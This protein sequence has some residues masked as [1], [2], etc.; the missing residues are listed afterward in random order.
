MANEQAQQLLQ[1]GIAAAKAGQ[2]DEA[3]RLLQEAIR[4]DATNETAWLWLSGVA[5]N[6]EE[7]IF[8][9]M[10]ILE[11]NPSNQNALKG[12][13]KLGV[14]PPSSTGIRRLKDQ[15]PPQGLEA[16]ARPPTA[17][18]KRIGAE[19]PPS[20]PAKPP[21]SDRIERRTAVPQPPVPILD[22]RRIA[23]L[24]EAAS[25][26]LENYQRLPEAALP[27]AWTRKTR[28]RIG[29][30][31][32]QALRL[33]IGAAFIGGIAVL[34]GAVFLILNL[35]GDGGTGVALRG[36]NTPTPTPTPTATPTF[37]LTNTPS[38]TPPVPRTATATPN[39]APGSIYSPTL[40]P[41]FPELRSGPLR[42]ALALLGAA[43]YAAALE[44]LEDERKGLELAKNETYY[45]IIYYMVTAY[46]AQNRPGEAARLL[47]ANRNP[48][49]TAFRAARALLS[50]A[51]GDLDTALSDALFVQRADPRW[52]EVAIVAARVQ[53]QRG[54]LAAARDVLRNAISANPRNVRLLL[55]RA[56]INLSGGALND[57]LSDAELALYIDPLN[58]SAYQI[59]NEALLTI[60]AAQTEPVA[61]VEAYGRAVIGAQAYLIYYP[62]DTEAWLQ[63]GRAREGEG[64]LSEALDAYRQAVVLDKSSEAARQVFLAQ[65][66]LLMRLR[67]YAEARD[68]F[69]AALT[70]RET[71]DVRRRRLD[72]AS[73]LGD[74]TT[75]LDDVT[76]LLRENPADTTLLR[77]QFDLLLAAWMA[78]ELTEAQFTTAAE[79]LSE[80][81]LAAF[82][83][84]ARHSA[85][86]YRGVVRYLEGD[87]QA[88]LSDLNQA[89]AI[90]ST[91]TGHYYRALTLRALDRP[92][93]AARDLQWLAYFEEFA[94]LPR[95]SDV[96]SLLAALVTALPTETATP[97][98][99][100]TN[101]PTATFTPSHVHAFT[102]SRRALSRRAAHR[103][104]H[105]RQRRRARLHQRAPSRR[106]ARRQ[107]RHETLHAEKA[108][109]F[110]GAFVQRRNLLADRSSAKIDQNK[111][112][113]SG[114]ESA[115]CFFFHICYA[116]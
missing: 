59:R 8:C 101:T 20:A 31:S 6:D 62:G 96:R 14:K 73:A 46:L 13:A 37:G 103:P 90:R 77:A 36:T 40:T 3:R 12:L 11:I 74:Y 111:T 85:V 70:I 38:N 58:R 63:L 98:P 22:E 84:Q 45:E 68:A 114:R 35:L 72:A 24:N 4:R 60:A 69:D 64:N 75:A 19:A 21:P 23:S 83:P 105:A 78:Q 110:L 116:Y 113:L 54:N 52:A 67:R 95:L 97:T 106:R 108:S 49:S 26:F 86:L 7:R 16:T 39:I 80:D 109:V 93:E 41:A 51:R 115:V 25:R 99:T 17:P 71:S 66:E 88:A 44:I 53:A 43:D 29:E 55:A 50:F 1:Q 61:R 89:L 28:G 104:S 5:S 65:G 15:P 27:F 10:K 82:T 94:T 56:E 100:A 9:L 57:A 79:R 48:D 76:L 91:A 112:C 34:A 33:R 87:Y 102:P 107:A 30:L 18:L 42:Q 92:A 2:R 81:Q 47:D 32:D